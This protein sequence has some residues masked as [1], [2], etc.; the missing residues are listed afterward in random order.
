[1]RGYLKAYLDSRQEMKIKKAK[2]QPGGILSQNE[3]EVIIN[4]YTFCIY[5]TLALSGYWPN[6]P[7]PIT[8]G[9]LSQ[10]LRTVYLV[11]KLDP[12]ISDEE[13]KKLLLGINPEVDGILLKTLEG[14]FV[15]KKRKRF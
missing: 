2:A 11:R 12:E 8:P 15:R 4:L 3:I 10:M 5:N 14:L 13:V 6:K 7:V 1:M 9:D